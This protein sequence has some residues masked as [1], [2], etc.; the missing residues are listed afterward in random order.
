MPTGYPVL[1][2]KQKEEIIHRIKENG[3]KVTDLAKEYGFEKEPK[4]LT[5]CQIPIAIKKGKMI[6]SSTLPADYGT[7]T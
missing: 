3:E 5:V 6:N 7:I 2:N 4:D 1:N